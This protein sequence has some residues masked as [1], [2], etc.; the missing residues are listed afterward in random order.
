MSVSS[1]KI[2]IKKNTIYSAISMQQT[3]KKGANLPKKSSVFA[4]PKSFF[5]EFWMFS[6]NQ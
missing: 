2:N 4:K 3:W 6:V 1:K 5:T